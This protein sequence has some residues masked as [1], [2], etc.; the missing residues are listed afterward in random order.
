MIKSFLD[1][2]NLKT[3]DDMPWINGLTHWRQECVIYSVDGILTMES[4][5]DTG[6]ILCDTSSVQII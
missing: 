2:L 4:I 5:Q 3:Y 1:N 6:F